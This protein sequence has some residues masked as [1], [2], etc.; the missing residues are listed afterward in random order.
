M[1][2]ELR[3]IDWWNA[4]IPRLHPV[5]DERLTMEEMLDLEPGLSELSAAVRAYNGKGTN[6]DWYRTIKPRMIALVG[7]R[8]R[9]PRLTS[10]AAY[11]AAYRYLYDLL[12][13]KNA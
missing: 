1:A 6:R 3:S 5:V 11:D 10:S 7:V 13:G 4:D 12:T 9:H 8:A 2:E